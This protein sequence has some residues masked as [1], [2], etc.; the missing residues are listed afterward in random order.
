MKRLRMERKVLSLEESSGVL[1]SLATSLG[2]SLYGA[3]VPVRELVVE[4][5]VD[6]AGVEGALMAVEEEEERGVYLRPC[7]CSSGMM[8]VGLCLE[9][10]GRWQ[11]RGSWIQSKT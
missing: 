5:G 6:W 1:P 4:A 3:G 11:G 8:V 7:L 2:S 9:M 10:T